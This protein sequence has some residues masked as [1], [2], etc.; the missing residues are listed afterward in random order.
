MP[1][2]WISIVILTSMMT[3]R[4]DILDLENEKNRM[5][6]K[7]PQIKRSSGCFGGICWRNVESYRQDG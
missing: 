4:T 1:S 7:E 2:F 3:R 6:K 5:V